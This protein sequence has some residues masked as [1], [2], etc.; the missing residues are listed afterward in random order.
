M[1]AKKK[2]SRQLCK[3]HGVESE[4]Q[5]ESRRVAQAGEDYAFNNLVLLFDCVS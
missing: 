4:A 2:P 5:S 3:V 1:V